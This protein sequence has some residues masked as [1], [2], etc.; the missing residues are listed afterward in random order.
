MS[1]TTAKQSLKRDNLLVDFLFQHKGKDN[2]VSAKEICDY[3]NENGYTAH[4]INI[5]IP[6]RRLMY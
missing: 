3:L 5:N 2:I 1:R 4:Q 6:I